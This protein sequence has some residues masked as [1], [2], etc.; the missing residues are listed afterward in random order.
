MLS[1]NECK[2]N[3]EHRSVI[4]NTEEQRGPDMA[5]KNEEKLS[6]ICSEPNVDS[7]VNGNINLNRVRKF[8]DEKGKTV[9]LVALP[10]HLI[11]VAKEIHV[12]LGYLR[13]PEL[14]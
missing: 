5:V 14:E 7:H 9:Y 12:S 11:E 4:P 2:N 6:R 3:V 13:R 8:V 10:E 1:Y